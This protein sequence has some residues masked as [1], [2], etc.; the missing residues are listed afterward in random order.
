M[1]A[2]AAIV[3]VIRDSKTKKETYGPFLNPFL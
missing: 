1:L 2:A 3:N